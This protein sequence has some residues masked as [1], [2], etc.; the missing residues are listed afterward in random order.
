MTSVLY[1]Y[2]DKFIGKYVTCPDVTGGPYQVEAVE[3][4]DSVLCLILRLSYASTRRID[5][6][7]CQIVNRP[8]LEAKI[9]NV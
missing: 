6:S 5:A 2:R 7:T 3:L 4:K 1:A 9:V 8:N